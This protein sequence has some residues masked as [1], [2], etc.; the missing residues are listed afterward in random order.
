[1]IYLL[2]MQAEERFS[3][4]QVAD[5]SGTPVPTIKHMTA[6]G[7]LEP[8]VQRARGRGTA[9]VYSF[10]D[11]VGAAALRTVW[12][13]GSSE[14]RRNVVRL[15]Q[16]R[17]GAELLASAEK[18]TETVIVIDEK[19]EVHVDTAATSLRTLAKRCGSSVLRVVFVNDII[20]AVRERAKT[21]PFLP[22]G[23]AGRATRSDDETKIARRVQS[24][25]MDRPKIGRRRTR[26]E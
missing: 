2:Q 10:A 16:G 11:V 14:A 25:M 20:K 21:T 3:A 9:N 24:L 19:G 15:F 22:P 26:E 18:C 12:D 23:P 7:V 8:S 17:G 5:I 1:M 4:E 13:V 6:H